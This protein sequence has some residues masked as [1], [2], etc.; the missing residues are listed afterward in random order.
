M[1]RAWLL[2]LALVCMACPEGASPTQVMV[3]VAAETSIADDTARLVVR[4]GGKPRDSGKAF[5]TSLERE[6]KRGSDLALPL[7]ITIA[8]AGGDAKRIYEFVATAYDASDTRIGEVRAISGFIEGRSLLLTLL[9]EESCRTISCESADLT[10][11]EGDCVDAHVDQ[12]E[13]AS[14]DPDDEPEDIVD[15]AVAQLP[16]DRDGSVPVPDEDAGTDAGL[17]PCEDGQIRDAQGEC[18]TPAECDE[19]MDCGEHLLC[20]FE[21]CSVC[22]PGWK[23][24]GSSC[25]DIDECADGVSG[26]TGECADID[27][28]FVCETQAMNCEAGNVPNGDQCMDLGCAYYQR[29]PGPGIRI[30]YLLDRSASMETISAMGTRWQVAQQGILAALEYD[31]F[32]TSEVSLDLVPDISQDGMCAGTSDVEFLP[33]SV[34]DAQS[35]L[36]PLFSMTSLAGGGAMRAGL[37]RAIDDLTS[38]ALVVMIFDGVNAACSEEGATSLKNTATMLAAEGVNILPIGLSGGAS[39]AELSALEV[40]IEDLSVTG[41]TNRFAR[42]TN[43]PGELSTAIHRAMSDADDCRR[44]IVEPP[45]YVG[46]LGDMRLFAGGQELM[47]YTFAADGAGMMS[48]TLTGDSCDLARGLND[49][50]VPADWYLGYEC[51]DR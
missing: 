20:A 38:G 32:D 49:E 19:D 26:C 37:T 9:L 3:V 22:E 45:S 33:M 51:G 10:C 47:Q 4:V 42:L 41:N 35:S 44:L 31:Y 6:F 50:A 30:R 7:S 18:V 36:P 39:G 25:V 34:K 17:P 21:T 14:F 13:L 28:S 48:V 40:L 29:L 24:V 8:P 43:D 16:G 23:L 46:P 15:D 27:G 1:K 11:R 5:E 2:V 12:G